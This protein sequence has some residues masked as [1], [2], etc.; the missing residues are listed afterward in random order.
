LDPV[1]IDVELAVGIVDDADA[2]IVTAAT[3]LVH[4]DDDAS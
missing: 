3:E 2:K 1:G 4:D